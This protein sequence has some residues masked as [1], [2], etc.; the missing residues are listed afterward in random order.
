MPHLLLGLCLWGV[1]QDVWNRSAFLAEQG[2]PGQE[3]SCRVVH[4]ASS[5]PLF[6]YLAEDGLC[7]AAGLG[8]ASS[9][10]RPTAA[11]V[12]SHRQPG[13]SGSLMARGGTAQ[14]PPSLAS[15]SGP[16][17]SSE[18]G[19]GTGPD[20]SGPC[21]TLSSPRRRGPRRVKS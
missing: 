21:R 1:S 18:G 9:T 13:L 5:F 7:R 11:L 20:P 17:C 12:P 8:K 10:P 4:E 2:E 3:S 14:P 15:Q 16:F 19:A 6:P